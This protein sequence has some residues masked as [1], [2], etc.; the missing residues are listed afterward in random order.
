MSETWACLPM[1]L[2]SCTTRQR[3]AAVCERLALASRRAPW[4]YEG[5]AHRQSWRGYAVFGHLSPARR[6]LPSGMGRNGRLLSV[7]V[8]LRGSA[9]RSQRSDTRALSGAPVARVKFPSTKLV[10][11]LCVSSTGCNPVCLFNY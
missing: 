5:I 8:P 4:L 10:S 2:L 9:S 3:P 6:P 1:H 7:R 11:G